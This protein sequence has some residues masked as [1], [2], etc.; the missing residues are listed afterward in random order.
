MRVRREP[1]VQRNQWVVSFALATMFLLGNSPAAA[2]APKGATIELVRGTKSLDSYWEPT[3]S[4]S[5]WGVGLVFHQL[6]SRFSLEMGSLMAVSNEKSI[7]SSLVGTTESSE[8]YLG[9]KKFIDTNGRLN[10]F[11]QGGWAMVSM[12]VTLRNSFDSISDSG[13]GTGFYWGTG[14]YYMISKFVS[15]GLAA[16]VT[17]AD[18]DFVGG[19]L[20]AGGTH[21]SATIGFFLE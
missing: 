5:E 18:V 8:Y 17:S 3:D 16:R 6:E 14:G 20:S 13:S 11:I 2:A 9:L 7:D 15:L 4:Q 19:D 1:N 10:L 12:K 21:L